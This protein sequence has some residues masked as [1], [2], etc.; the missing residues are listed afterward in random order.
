MGQSAFG[1]GVT[2]TI[3]ETSNVGVKVGMVGRGV[4]D[5]VDVA[6]GMDVCAAVDVGVEVELI[7]T[8]SGVG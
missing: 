3:V 6:E 7:E 4:K 5:A 8:E 1:A 2:V